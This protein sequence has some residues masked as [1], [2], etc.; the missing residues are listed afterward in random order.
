VKGN[1]KFN[2]STGNNDDIVIAIAL[3]NHGI[4]NEFYQKE[5]K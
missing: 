4:Y 2:A 5:E 1:E 3:V